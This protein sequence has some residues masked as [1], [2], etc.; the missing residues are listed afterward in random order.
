[1]SS[2]ITETFVFLDKC[3]QVHMDVRLSVQVK[4]R[5]HIIPVIAA[6][7]VIPVLVHWG[8]V[9][10]N[11]FTAEGFINW[12]TG[13]GLVIGRSPKSRTRSHLYLSIFYGRFG[14]EIIT[15]P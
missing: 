10:G 13:H 1:M 7:P 5:T 3:W 9:C 8:A 12:E 4:Q 2:K 14:E 6:C 11:K 15:I